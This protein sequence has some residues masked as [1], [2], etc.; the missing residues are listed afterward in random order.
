MTGN[1]A[2]RSAIRAFFLAAMLAAI[3][4]P[5]AGAG[6]PLYSV[7][8]NIA[9]E[10]GAVR[11]IDAEE[12]ARIGS[13]EVETKVLTLGDQKRRVKGVLARELVKYLGGKGQSLRISALD[14]YIIDIPMSDVES[15]DV[16][17][18]TEIDGK[19][20][21]IRDRGPAWF[22]YPISHH[23]E[24]DESIYESRSVWQVKTIEIN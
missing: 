17:I 1:L 18:A 2:M 21:S 20:L 22:I 13:V 11:A 24:L 9:T 6:Q 19:P 16:V 10:H 3:A 14:G 7:T 4:M 15:Y 12:I 8:G 23:P 5:P